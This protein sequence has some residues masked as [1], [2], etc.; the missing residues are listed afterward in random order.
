MKD[1]DPDLD[2]AFDEP[3]AVSKVNSAPSESGAQSQG[4][5]DPAVAIGGNSVMSDDQIFESMPSVSESIARA[6]KKPKDDWASSSEFDALGE[7]Q[8]R[9]RAEQAANAAFDADA[10]DEADEADD[11]D[12][13]A[14]T[15]AFTRTPTPPP[16][17]PDHPNYAHGGALDSGPPPAAPMSSGGLAFEESSRDQPFGAQSTFEESPREELYS[18]ESAFEEAPR[19]ELYANEQAFDEQYDDALDDEFAVEVEVEAAIEVEAPEPEAQGMDDEAFGAMLE[20]AWSD[21]E[22]QRD[23]PSKLQRVAFAEAAVKIQT[24]LVPNR[25]LQMSKNQLLAK[26]NAQVEAQEGLIS[27]TPDWRACDKELGAILPKLEKLVGETDKK[28]PASR[29]RGAYLAHTFHQETC[30]NYFEQDV[31]SGDLGIGWWERSSSLAVASA[32]KVLASGLRELLPV[33]DVVKLWNGRLP[34]Q[35][36]QRSTIVAAVRFFQDALV[37]IEAMATPKDYFS[38]GLALEVIGYQISLREDV[39]RPE[40]LYAS[41]EFHTKL[42]NWLSS[43]ENRPLQKTLDGDFKDAFEKAGS[44][45]GL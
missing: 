30:L 22:P 24:I 40:V 3:T 35:K 5:L 16:D 14:P 45:F 31:R 33:A 21:C 15:A 39:F 42:S 43:E 1:A 6:P 8:K 41:A 25:E 13:D 10:D 2:E 36:M 28:I 4:L 29:F 27:Y 11:Q 23:L 34:A 7:G 17:H 19:E 20:E 44:I 37:K 38:S 26:L 12:F 32:S 18:A 9:V